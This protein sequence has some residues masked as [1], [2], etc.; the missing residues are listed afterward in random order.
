MSFSSCL[1]YS[2]CCLPRRSSLMLMG[3][4]RESLFIWGFRRLRGTD[5]VAFFGRFTRVSSSRR[6]SAIDDCSTSATLSPWELNLHRPTHNF[7][8]IS[9]TN[10]CA[11]R[12]RKEFV[13]PQQSLDVSAK[14]CEGK[15]RQITVQMSPWGLI[16]CAA[17]A[18]LSQPCMHLKLI[19]SRIGS[20]FS[21]ESL[22]IMQRERRE[23]KAHEMGWK[24]LSAAQQ[25]KLQCWACRG[26]I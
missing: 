14:R 17:L 21:A 15:A 19:E 20:I 25:R 12:N 8:L 6:F 22:K 23:K 3:R 7:L 9:I 1:I 11:F 2:S 5:E 26:R 13:S 16:V 10:R 18:S 24:C 4:E